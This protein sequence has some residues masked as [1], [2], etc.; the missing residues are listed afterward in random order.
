MDDR[1]PKPVYKHDCESCVF[2]GTFEHI[3]SGTD[4]DL[5]VMA[6]TDEISYYNI[7]RS[8]EGSD[9]I[10]TNRPEDYIL[11]FERSKR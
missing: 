11:G 4:C 9:Y 6:H 1:W 8:N 3:Y 7:R 5:W 10:T 2:V